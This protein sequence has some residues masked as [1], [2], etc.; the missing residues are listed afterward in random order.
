V[1]DANSNQKIPDW[2]SW[3][4]Q[5]KELSGTPVK[6]ETIKLKITAID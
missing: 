1:K 2:L 4:E 6:K 5:A 3:D